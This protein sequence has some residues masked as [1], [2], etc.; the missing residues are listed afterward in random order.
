MPRFVLN[1]HGLTQFLQVPYAALNTLWFLGLFALDP[2]A[3]SQPDY[4]LYLPS[5]SGITGCF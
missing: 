1:L 5:S 4:A 3:N 2:A